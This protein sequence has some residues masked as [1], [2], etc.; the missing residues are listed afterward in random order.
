MTNNETITYSSILLRLKEKIRTARQKAILVVNNH[1]L[2]T[3]WEI[4]HTIAKQEQQAGWGGKVIEKLAS[5]LKAEF[6]EMKGLSARNLRY[7]RD[8]SL[9]YPDFLQHIAAKTQDP[10]NQDIVI[11]QQ[12]AA[13]LPWGHHQLLLTETKF[14]SILQF[15]F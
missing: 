6:P 4:G 5:D 2:S 7:M 13:K 9:A 3:Y 11:L 8:F 1:L 15:K 12:L 10:K 14:P